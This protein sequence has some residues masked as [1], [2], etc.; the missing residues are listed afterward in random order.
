MAIETK[1]LIVN[2][3]FVHTIIGAVTIDEIGNHFNEFWEDLLMKVKEK[4]ESVDVIWDVSKAHSPDLGFD[5]MEQLGRTIKA[6]KV[7]PL[8]GK[9]VLIQPNTPVKHLIS[10][11]FELICPHFTQRDMKIVNSLK[12]AYDV[13]AYK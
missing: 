13:V 4:S 2:K 12:T 11:F 1:Q 9:T 10:Y 3:L 8:K 5:M 6:V 7:Q